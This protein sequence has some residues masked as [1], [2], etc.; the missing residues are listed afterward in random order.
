MSDAEVT[1]ADLAVDPPGD[2]STASTDGPPRR[3]VAPFV[4]LGVAVVIAALLV[5]LAAGNAS[6]DESADSALLGKPAPTTRGDLV[7]G[8]SFDLSRRKGSW[9]LLNFFDPACGPCVAEHPELVALAQQ[10]GGI[11][12]GAE[13]YTIISRQI[14]PRGDDVSDIV[15]FFADNGGDW[16][17][18]EDPTGG[19][20]VAYGVSQVPETWIVDPNGIVR[21]RLIGQITADGVGALL[22]ELREGTA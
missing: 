20:S 13:L 12:G 14:S 22:Q 2:P 16:P 15:Q 5:F 7:G 19:I 21:K 18:V 4:V 3:R 17:I 8:G 1:D 11:D 6:R 9:V 10:Q